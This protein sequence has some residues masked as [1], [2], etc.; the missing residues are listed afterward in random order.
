MI[1]CSSKWPLA[2]CGLAALALAGRGLLPRRLD[3]VVAVAPYLL[4]PALALF[5]LFGA[6]VPQLR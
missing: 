5:G 1:L 2:F 3:P 4:L 6:I